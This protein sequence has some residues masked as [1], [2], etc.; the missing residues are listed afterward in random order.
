MFDASRENRRKKCSLTVKTQLT[1]ARRQIEMYL[2]GFEAD[3][4]D[5]C[6]GVNAVNPDGVAA[7][8]PMSAEKELL[9][10]VR[11]AVQRKIR[12]GETRLLGLRN[13]A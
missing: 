4:R 12:E 1:S 5:A 13:A 10:V 11:Y 9:P 8:H 6:P 3:W 7:I 2:R